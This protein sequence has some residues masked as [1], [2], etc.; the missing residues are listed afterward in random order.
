VTDG[1][2]RIRVT[3]TD[4]GDRS[5]A[6]VFFRIILLIPHFIWLGLWSAGAFLISPIHWVIA[7]I[8]GRPAEWAYGFYSAYVRYALH[9]FAYFY[10]AT[11]RYPGFI[12]ERGY[13]V[14]AEFPPR[15]NQRRW[16]IA[17]RF[18][19][20]LPALV[21]A[22][23]LSGGPGGNYGSSNQSNDAESVAFTFGGLGTAVAFLAW[24]ASL[25]LARTPG[26]LRDAQV[27]CQAYAAQAFGY[28]F[29][30]SDRYPTSDPDAIALDPMPP[31]P[32]RLRVGEERARN[33]LTVFFR[34]LLAIPHIIWLWLWAIAALFAAIAGWIAALATGRLPG[35]LHGF[36]SAFVR[37]GTHVGS[38]VYIL[39]DPFPGFLGRAGSYPVDPEIDDPQPQHRAKTGFRLVLALPAWLL[40]GGFGTV[41]LVCAVGVWFCALFTGRI[42]EGLH[43]L[44]AWAI[45]YEAQFYSYLL[46]LTERYP[47]TGP[48]GRGRVQ[49]EPPAE[50]SDWQLAP[51]RP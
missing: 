22:S 8:L 26:G 43:G 46:L 6:A 9:V 19:I 44:L 4:D 36:L 3:H 51:E 21:L 14:D 48:D 39:A 15:E 41:A 17:L 13:A 49:P 12:G 18:F 1:E 23:A 31:H 16:T 34:L 30:L 5:R 10:L 7:L 32:V 2:G 50:P 11:G 35:A 38:Y 42:P 45:R 28:L 40:A 33:R 29:L 27:Y 20:A 37:Y 47:Y 25:A 24:F